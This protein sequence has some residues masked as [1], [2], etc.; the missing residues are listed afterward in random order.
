MG[1]DAT[2]TAYA[3]IFLSDTG[4]PNIS[5]TR[6]KVKHLAAEH[7][8]GGWN[9]E[10]LREAHDFLTLAEIYSALAYYYD[11]KDEID[12]ELDE[13]DR[14]AEA[15][16]REWEKTPQAAALRAKIRAARQRA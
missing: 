1:W 3:H 16:R 7:R 12:R 6:F 14:I 4:I 9:A 2:P 15:Y 11:H 10:E 8:N 5:G 13:G